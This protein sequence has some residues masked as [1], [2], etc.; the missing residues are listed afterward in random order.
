V[1]IKLKPVNICKISFIQGR[2]KIGICKKLLGKINTSCS[3][4]YSL[5]NSHSLEC[6]KAKTAL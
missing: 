3:K 5:E 6:I 4:K 2:A 1:E